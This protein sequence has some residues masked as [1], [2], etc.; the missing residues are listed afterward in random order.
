MC[1]YNSLTRVSMHFHANNNFDKCTYEPACLYNL[2][3][4]VC[5]TIRKGLATP[6]ALSIQMKQKPKKFSSH[7]NEIQ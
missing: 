5:P 3:T 2:V 7:L 6:L 4:V 1:F